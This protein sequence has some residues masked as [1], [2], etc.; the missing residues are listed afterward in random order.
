MLW[1]G[2]LLRVMKGAGGKGHL[3]VIKG[4]FGRER[5]DDRWEGNEV[6]YVSIKPHPFHPTST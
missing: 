3:Q 6:Q 4:L 1:P 5:E 2:R